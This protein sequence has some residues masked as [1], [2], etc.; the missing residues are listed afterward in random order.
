MQDKREVAVKS[1]EEAVRK[2]HLI[3]EWTTANLMP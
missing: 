2:Q 3:V 1:K